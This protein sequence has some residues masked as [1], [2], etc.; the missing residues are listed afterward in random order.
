MENRIVGWPFR[1]G[2]EGRIEETDCPSAGGHG[3]LVDEGGHAGPQG[4][5]A[6][7]A[8]QSA[9]R[10]VAASGI[11]VV[12][13]QG[14]IREVALG[15][16][17]AVGG[18]VNTGLPGWKGIVGADAAAAANVLAVVGP[19]V[20]DGLRCPGPAGPVVLKVVPPTIVM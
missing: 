19:G 5:C 8:A 7:G 17:A 6:T 3:L 16:R 1:K 12:R 18:H 13:G 11:Q 20:P 15:G 4:G 14:Y 2:V 10:A 9:A